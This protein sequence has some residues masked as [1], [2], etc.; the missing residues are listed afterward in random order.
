MY[1]LKQLTCICWSR[2]QLK[3]LLDTVNP[4]LLFLSPALWAVASLAMGLV[5]SPVFCITWDGY[6]AKGSCLQ[7]HGFNRLM[8]QGALFS[9]R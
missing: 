4:G 5:C 7:K 3:A 6:G 8:H 9:C 1:Y 2:A